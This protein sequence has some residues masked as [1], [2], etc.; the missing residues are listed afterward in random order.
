M[1]ERAL[2]VDERFQHVDDRGRSEVRGD[3]ERKDHRAPKHERGDDGEREPDDA[4]ATDV[5][6]RY[7][8]RVERLGAV[9]DDPTFEPLVEADQTGR[10]LL[11]WSISCCGSNGLPTNADAPCSSACCAERSSTWPLNM[12]TGIEP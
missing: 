10:M 5:R 6:Q 9:R 7:E 4:E 1:I 8:D 12:I 2:P 11:A 3:D